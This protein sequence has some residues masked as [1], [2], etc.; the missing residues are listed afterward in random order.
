MTEDEFEVVA[1]AIV[2]GWQGE[3]SEDRADAYRVF[4]LPLP[5]PDVLAAL[6]KLAEGGSPWL[7]TVPE[8]VKA[9]RDVQDEAVP[10][11]REAWRA[12]RAAMRCRDEE[13]AY[14]LLN[15]VH[16]VVARFMTACG[17]WQA[18]RLVP[19][20]D[21]QYGAL[22]VRELREDWTEFVAVARERLRRGRALDAAQPRAQIGPRKLDTH[23]L[24]DG[25]RPALPSGDE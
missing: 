9:T 6:S 13:A 21:E 25:L 18:M 22:R 24:V 14:A 16:P 2:Q 4:L 15:D 23:A 3:W 1:N 19:F 12:L 5:L 17:G 10:S 20:E 8:I 11:W 7:P